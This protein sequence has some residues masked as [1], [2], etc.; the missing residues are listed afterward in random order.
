M[1]LS[2]QLSAAAMSGTHFGLQH[3]ACTDTRAAWLITLC[4]LAAPCVPF[5]QHTTIILSIH[6]VLIPAGSPAAAAVAAAGAGTGSSGHVQAHGNSSYC[7]QLQDDMDHLRNRFN[8]QAE[9][10]QRVRAKC[11]PS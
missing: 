11:L 1:N 9:E 6:V 4:I 3:P 5:S 8:W 2:W 10:L 7:S